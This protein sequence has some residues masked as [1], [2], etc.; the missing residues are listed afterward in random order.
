MNCP[1]EIADVILNII[2]YGILNARATA[3]S[4][5]AERSA[6]EADHIHNLPDLLSEYS[7]AKLD[8]YWDIERPCYLSCLQRAGVGNLTGFLED[9]NKLK[10]IVPD[11]KS[12]EDI[13][14]KHEEN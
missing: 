2:C 4:N 8:Y 5:D 12:E 14:R 7:R 3:W 11:L 6:C 1:E 9:W 10:E 13:A